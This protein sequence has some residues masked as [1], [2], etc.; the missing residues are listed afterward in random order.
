MRAL[1]G[2]LTCAATSALT[3]SSVYLVRARGHQAGRVHA[4]LGR[5]V[6]SACFLAYGIHPGTSVCSRRQPVY[7]WQQI[8]M[9]V[10]CSPLSA[11][12]PGVRP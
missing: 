3:H 2:A 1:A 6:Q 11:P 5:A 7:A 9:L 12:I 10:A 4:P 8:C